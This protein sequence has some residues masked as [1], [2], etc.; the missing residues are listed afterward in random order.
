MLH[1]PVTAPPEWRNGRA[2]HSELAGPGWELGMV[3]KA[4]P[5]GLG[6]AADADRSARPQ[7]APR[8]LGRRGAA[9]V[10][11]LPRGFELQGPG[12]KGTP[13]QLWGLGQVTPG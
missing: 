9:H 6:Q 11:S 13:E 4:Q 5:P 2:S 1:K 10:N 7:L 3:R 8:C 12:G